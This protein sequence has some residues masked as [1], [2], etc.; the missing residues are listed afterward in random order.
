ME[1]G[2]VADMSLRE[3]RAMIDEIVQERL[4]AWPYRAQRSGTTG[5]D[6]WQHLLDNMIEPKAG[7]PSALDMLREE[8]E[9]WS[10]M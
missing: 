3:L 6:A 1:H 9:Q 4:Q 8:R 2:R 10:N 5:P 7:E